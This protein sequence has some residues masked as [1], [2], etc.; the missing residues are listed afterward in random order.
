MPQLIQPASLTDTSMNILMK[1][2]ATC[3]HRWS[4]QGSLEK[5]RESVAVIKRDISPL[6][7]HNL[8][9]RFHDKLLFM[10]YCLRQPRDPHRSRSHDKAV[11]E[12]IMDTKIRGLTF[13]VTP[14]LFFL[15]LRDAHRIQGLEKLD[16]SLFWNPLLN[17][18]AS[19]QLKDLIKFVFRNEC[20]DADLQIIGQNCPKLLTLDVSGS[21]K[22]TDVGLHALSDCS[23]LCIVSVA[24]CSVS[25]NG[26]N[27]LLSVNKKIY[28]LSGWDDN[29]F[30]CLTH[31]DA[32]VYPSIQY[33]ELEYDYISNELLRSMVS[34]FPN[35]TMTSVSGKLLGDINVLQNLQK[36][37][38][39]DLAEVSGL[40]WD[41]I[42]S[43]LR[44]VGTKM[45]E[46]SLPIDPG[47]A[48]VVQ[49]DLN[50]IFNHCGN[51]ESLTFAHRG[52]IEVDKLTVP[53]FSKLKTLRCYCLR[54]SHRPTSLEFGRMLKLESIWITGFYLSTEKL[55]S[56]ILNHSYFPNLKSI[57]ISGFRNRNDSQ[58]LRQVVRDNNIK[59]QFAG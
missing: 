31:E 37:S 50:F 53:P 27:D 18:L 49:N 9:A 54:D 44:D 28:M 16:I 6:I 36:L 13:D 26:I 33:F 10:F 56:M 24:C 15:D 48:I 34:K 41:N 47:A 23:N 11:L 57:S 14:L 38:R 21:K 30:D 25:L 12:I 22:V 17:S 40:T 46:L 2:C 58:H 55:E 20:T 29:G 39:L 35:L 43:F 32:S 19:F 52:D 59:F 4:A 3:C 8:S 1:F 5:L 51:L 42:Q 7:P 45:I